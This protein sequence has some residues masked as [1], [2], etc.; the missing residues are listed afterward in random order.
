MFSNYFKT[1]LRN[2]RR[3]KVYAIVNIIGLSIG[4]ACTILTLRWVQYELSFDRYHEKADRIYRLATEM[5]LGNMRGRYAV[6]NYIAGKTLAR[7]Y[8][9]VE[10]SVRFQRVPFKLLLQYKDI[11]FYEDNISIADNTVFDIFTFPLIKG[12]PQNA[13]NSAFSIVITEDLA[14]KYFGNKDPIGS[15]IRANNDVDLTVT[16]VMQNVPRNSHFI[17]DALVSFEILRHVYDNY[18]KEIEEDW[19]DHDNFTYLLLREDYDYRDLE[20]KFPAFIEKHMGTTLKAIGGKV[21]YFLQPLIQI[22]LESKLEIDTNNTDIVYVFAFSMIAI[23]VLCIAC[24][25]FMNLSTGRSMSRAKEV[26]VRKAQGAQRS[27]LIHQFFCEAFLWSCVSFAGSL[28]LVEIA[29]P[30]FHW[31]SGIDL[32]SIS[33]FKPWFILGCLGLVLFVAFVAG[34]YPAVYLSGFQTIQVLTGRLKIGPAG[35]PFRN[36]LVVGQFTISIGLIIVSAIIFAQIHY[37]KNERLGFNK[38]Q[39][40]VLRM[41]GDSFEKSIPTIK[42]ELS[43]YSGVIDVTASSQVPGGFSGWHAFVPQGYRL[44]QTQIMASI[45]IDPDFIPMMGIQIVDG[46]NFSD[47]IIEDQAES[48]LINEEAAKRFGWKDPVGKTIRNLL[49]KTN[50]TVIGV[51]SNFHLKSLH[52]NIMPLY[53]DY[54]PAMHG[55]VSIKIKPHDIS[56]TLHFLRKKWIEITPAQTLDYFFLAEAFDQQYRDDEKLG[57]ILSNFSVLAIL[58]AC[59][60]LFG[61]AFFTVEKR[62]KEIGIRKALGASVFSIILFLLKEFTKLILLA[63]VIAWPIAYFTMNRWLQNYAYRI[64]IGLSAF[65]LAGLIV[66][67]IALLAVGYQAIKAA[68]ANPVDALRYE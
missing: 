54:N 34:I 39:I 61:L 11:Q 17:F 57:I 1:A 25:N 68:R 55:Y 62:T 3:H 19:M 29:L 38:K 23:F 37:M 16:G 24:I 22:H 49:N 41:V 52:H 47:D 10:K 35:S 48:I 5:D 30:L 31:L 51:V 28:G 12:D 4:M 8:P 27:N 6:S 58:I 56:K 9:E 7:D 67:V 14:Q 40:V 15:I 18:Q 26:G 32:S 53:I 50:K 43:S 42:T 13:L 59:L 2:I 66:L 64:E 20:N 21:E 45:S 36:T 33:I 65:A 63:N 44:D 60:G 46:R